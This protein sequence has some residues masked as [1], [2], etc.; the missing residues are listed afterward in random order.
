MNNSR[1]KNLTL[2]IAQIALFVALMTVFTLYVSI[3]FFPVPLTFQ[4]VI[5]VCAGLFLGKKKGAIAMA[6]Y[7]FAGLVCHLPIFSGATGGF[8]SVFKP[9]FGYIIGFVVAAYAAGAVR[10]DITA[11]TKKYVLAAV[12]GFACCYAIGIPYFALI[13]KYYL[14][15][16]NVWQAILSYNILYMPKDIVLCALA[17][18]VAKRLVPIIFKNN[19]VE[20]TI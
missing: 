12:V 20:K 5:C 17:S 2:D 6:V 13:W 10:G 18:V 11:S 19:V 8:A 14:G 9:S 3:P 7:L 15:N 4:A 16:D 1:N